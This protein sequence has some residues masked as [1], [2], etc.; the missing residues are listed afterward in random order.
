[1]GSKCNVKIKMQKIDEV[2]DTKEYQ[3][4]QCMIYE[5]LIQWKDML[6]KKSIWEP[7]M[8][9]QQFPHIYP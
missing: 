9:I 1:M 4:H 5:V 6:I 7:I 8:I 3:L 2:L